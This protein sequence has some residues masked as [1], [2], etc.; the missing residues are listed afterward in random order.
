MTEKNGSYN[1]TLKTIDIKMDRVWLQ[2]ELQLYANKKEKKE[3]TKVYLNLSQFQT[4][5]RDGIIIIIF[6]KNKY[7]LIQIKSSSEVSGILPKMYKLCL[8]YEE[9]TSSIY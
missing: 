1:L 4:A 3:L 5:N 8:E 9:K 2:E 6:I 7:W